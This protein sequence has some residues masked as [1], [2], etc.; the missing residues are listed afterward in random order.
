LPEIKDYFEIREV[1]CSIN[2]NLEWIE[3]ET[4]KFKEK[5]EVYSYLWTIDPKDSFE[6]FLSEN[7]PKDAGEDDEQQ[8]NNQL[9]QG[10]RAKMP[11]L[12][13]FD[14]KITNLKS[15]QNEIMK[16]MTPFDISWLRINL[17]PLKSA[18]ENKVTSWIQV[19]T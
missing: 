16:I 14:D 4:R 3:E 12:D 10:C 13:L 7:E 11:N 15:I 8:A 9:L 1:V 5:Y 6:E 2:V 17:Q 18:L 19:Y